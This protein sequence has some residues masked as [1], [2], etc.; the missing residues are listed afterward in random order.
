MMFSSM[1]LLCSLCWWHLLTVQKNLALLQIVSC[2]TMDF[3]P[4]LRIGRAI[5][6]PLLLLICGLLLTISTIPMIYRIFL[7]MVL[8]LLPLRSLVT[9]FKKSGLGLRGLNA[10]IG[11]RE[12]TGHRFRLL[13]GDLINNLDIA[14]P[15]MEGIDDF[16]VLDVWDRVPSVV[17]MLHII[18]EAFCNTHFLRIIKF[19][20]IS[21]ALGCIFLNSIGWNLALIKFA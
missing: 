12:Q 5:E 14:D 1:R 8:L 18:P 2:D 17:E 6:R 4:L 11:D 16:D 10:H 19:C 9:W 13:H 15:V 20:R 7:P 3:T 21:S